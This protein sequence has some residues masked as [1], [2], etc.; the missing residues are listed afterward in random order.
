MRMSAMVG[1]VALAC[2][3]ALGPIAAAALN[4]DRLL[5]QPCEERII[6]LNG[7][8]DFPAV[9]LV[10]SADVILVLLPHTDITTVAPVEREVLGDIERVEK[11]TAPRTIIYTANTFGAFVQAG[12]RAK[13]FLKKFPDRDAH[14]IIARLPPDILPPGVGVSISATSYGGEPAR[15]VRV[16]SSI[17]I[18]VLVTARSE[19]FAFVVD[20][21]AGFRRPD[22]T[23]VW[24]SGTPL[25]PT[26]VESTT[27]V[28]FLKAASGKSTAIGVT[29]RLSEADP[30]GW[31]TLFAAVV[32]A[33]DDPSDPCA[34]RDVFS[35]PLQVSDE[36]SSI[37]IVD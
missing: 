34:W 21:Y 15:V 24:V 12:V 28:P 6:L 31:Y 19:L 13:L 23:S 35:V 1:A 9:P 2:L 16:G 11:G 32:R 4:E 30:P 22:G 29:Y 7:G 33:G 10:E 17:L 26:T 3:I 36:P 27:P 20:V 18:E 8:I 14:Y 5:V 37:V 25:A